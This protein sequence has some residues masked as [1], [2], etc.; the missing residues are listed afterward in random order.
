MKLNLGCGSK[1]LTGYTNIDKFDFYKPD[2]LHDLE[3]FPYPFQDNS[4]D[5]IILSHVLEHLGQAPETF[6]NIIKEL[7]R[8][9][10]NETIIN[11]SVP[12]PRHDEFISDPTHVRPITVLGLSLYNKKL[13]KKWEEQKASN[14]PLGFILD[15]NFEII[16]LQYVVDQ[17]Y[18][19]LL[20]EKKIS[21]KEIEDHAQKFNNV[22]KEINIKWKVIK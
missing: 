16:S 19:N 13:N 9:C 6:N 11:I 12:H 10:K 20:K 21:E 7:Y 4:V 2:L 5:E 14:T 8:V 18:Q 17:K 1:L 22:I 15:V 3:K